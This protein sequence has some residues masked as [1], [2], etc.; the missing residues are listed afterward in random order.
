MSRPPLMAVARLLSADQSSVLMSIAITHHHSVTTVRIASHSQSQSVAAHTLASVT[1]TSATTSVRLSAQPATPDTSSALTS[2]V[3]LPDVARSQQLPPLHTSLILVT[4]LSQSSHTS[5]QQPPQPRPLLSSQL[6]TASASTTPARPD[7]TVRSGLLVHASHAAAL[8]Q[9]LLNVQ[10]LS[11]LLQHHVPTTNTSQ[12]SMMSTSAASQF[13][14][15]RSSARRHARTLTVQR[16]LS[17][18]AS[19]TRTARAEPSMLTAAATSTTAN[20][21][22]TSATIL[23]SAHAHQVSSDRSSTLTLAAQLLDAARPPSQFHQLE[24]VQ[25]RQ[26][27]TLHELSLTPL[28]LPTSSPPQL[29]SV[30]TVRVASVNTVRAGH[31]RRSHA[32]LT[33]VSL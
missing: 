16:L 13:A 29:Q 6:R 33:H 20:A 11:A 25:S 30:S 23:A 28:Q 10:R 12:A 26:L 32:S 22:R 31:T 5:F 14:V 21:T 27:H 19:T 7:T 3:Q 15:L 4:L 17:Q 2:V 8:L 18:L 1:E 9:V 24:L